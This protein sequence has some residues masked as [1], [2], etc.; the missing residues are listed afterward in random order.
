MG[1]NERYLDDWGVRI[2]ILGRKLVL[3]F[4]GFSVTN[5]N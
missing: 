3:R 1:G 4:E 5:L 2:A